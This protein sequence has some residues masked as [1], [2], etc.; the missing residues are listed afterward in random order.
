MSRRRPNR[1]KASDLPGDVRAFLLTGN[2]F[3]SRSITD[4]EKR[5]C[6]ELHR[7]ELVS[8][9]MQNPDTWVRG[10]LCHF[11]YPAPV[12]PGFRPAGFWMYGGHE[13]QLLEWE[14]IKRRERDL[15]G[16]VHYENIHF[17]SERQETQFEY[18]HRLDL[19]TKAEHRWFNQFPQITFDDWSL[20]FRKGWQNRT[21]RTEHIRMSHRCLTAKGKRWARL[22]LAYWHRLELQAPLPATGCPQIYDVSA[23]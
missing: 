19:L 6:W 8:Y 12:G 21:G 14:T 20:L 4:E 3:S 1:R 22:D 5:Q 17:D 2:Y 10:E 11:D 9:W 18:L 15:L 16:E 13:R 7:D 23:A